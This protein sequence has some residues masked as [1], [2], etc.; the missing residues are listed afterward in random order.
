MRRIQGWV[1]SVGRAGGLGFAGMWGSI[2][3]ATLGS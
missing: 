1:S 2:M 3:V